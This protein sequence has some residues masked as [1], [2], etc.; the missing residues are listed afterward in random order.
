MKLSMQR[1]AMGVARPQREAGRVADRCGRRL[2]ADGLYTDS[3][4]LIERGRAAGRRIVIAS[5]APHLYTAALAR[6]LGIA[7]VVASASCWKN[8]YLTPAIEGAN[9]Y[10]GDKKLC[11]EAFLTKA[12]IARE[13]RKSTRLNSSH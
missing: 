3:V 9:C 7:D 6:R 4:A 2:I 5:A 11:V 1:M 10:G 12:G 13:D 8:G